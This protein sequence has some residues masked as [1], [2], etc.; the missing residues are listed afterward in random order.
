M[1][2]PLKVGVRGRFRLD[3]ID[4]DGNVRELAPW[5]DNLITDIGL[6][7]LAGWVT[8]SPGQPGDPDFNYN[9]QSCTQYCFV[10]SGSTPPTV[11]DTQPGAFIA[12]ATRGDSIVKASSTT[13][14]WYT[15][16]IAVYQFAVGAAAGN[17][18]EVGLDNGNTTT[19]Q[20]YKYWMFSRALI[21][22][23]AGDPI[24]VTVLPTEILQVSYETRTYLDTDALK[25]FKVM[26]GTT[27][28]TVRMRP[29]GLPDS[30]TT[31]RFVNPD[32]SGYHTRFTD[33]AWG[34]AMVRNSPRAATD[35]APVNNS[36]PTGWYGGTLISQTVGQT[37]GPI[38]RAWGT[39]SRGWYQQ[40]GVNTDP[41]ALTGINAFFTYGG[42]HGLYFNGTFSPGLNKSAD[43]TLRFEWEVTWGRYVP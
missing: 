29:H 38:E 14:P 32:S 43:E 17:L 4:P 12:R 3:V 6:N 31:A 22:N 39:W 16:G 11:G 20:G 21:K 26:D 30:S 36:N 34:V 8:G 18:S 28:I 23:A 41:A 15:G 37:F 2:I 13:A 19:S 5:Q 42:A 7:V 1:K 9:S 10:G 27:E 24:T 33:Y 25:E 35:L 40:L